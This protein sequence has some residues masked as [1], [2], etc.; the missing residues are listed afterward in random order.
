MPH[1]SDSEQLPIPQ[2]LIERRIYIIR[3]L[4]VMLDAD[5]AELYQI[6]TRAL[7]Q[8]VRR[9]LDRFPEDFM[10]QLSEQEASAL[11]SQTVTLEKGRGLHSKYA[12][13]AFAEHG[14]LMLSSV[15]NS[16]RAVQMSI[17][18]VRVFIQLRETLAANKDL[19]ARIERLEARQKQHGSVLAVIVDEIKTLKQEPAR[20]KRRIGFATEPE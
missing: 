5:L 19:A 17:R 6:E 7:N 13:F 2:E 9:N 20:P 3:G 1:K 8:A 4:K 16:Q 10:F 11:R 14:A 15:L 12:P 18:V